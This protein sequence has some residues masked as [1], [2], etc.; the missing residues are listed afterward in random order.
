MISTEN[1]KGKSGVYCAIHRDSLKCYVGSSH[2]IGG[3]RR[4]HLSLAR[5]GSS[6][7]FHCAIRRHGRESFDFEVLEFCPKAQL[8]D[9]ETFWIRFYQSAGLKGFNTLSI[10]NVAPATKHSEATRARL[11]E[12]SLNMSQETRE[13][14]RKASLGRIISQE[15]REKIREALK[16]RP[17]ISEETRAKMK[18]SRKKWKTPLVTMLARLRLSEAGKRRAPASEETRAKLKEAWKKRKPRPEGCFKRSEESK[19]KTRESI[20]KWWAEKGP[21]PQ[22]TKDRISKSLI[23]NIPWNSARK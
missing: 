2:N 4:T 9:R 13:K 20:S 16:N 5:S 14:I 6:K 7:N 21:M 12:A 1:L 10:A 11:R 3:R 8:T 18:V 19:A 23:G 17:P 22:E 15:T